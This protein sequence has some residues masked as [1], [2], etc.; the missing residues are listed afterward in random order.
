M[1]AKEIKAKLGE[2]Q[3]RSLEKLGSLQLKRL[4]RELQKISD[5]LDAIEYLIKTEEL[6]N[7][8]PLEFISFYQYF[9]KKSRIKRPKKGGTALAWEKY[10]TEMKKLT[11]QIQGKKNEYM[12]VFD[13]LIKIDEDTGI[14]LLSG[15]TKEDKKVLTILGSITVKT[16]RGVSTLALSEVE[17]NNR[18]WIQEVKNVKH[19]GVL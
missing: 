18:K 17:S 13:K 5:S 1:N 3:N 8:I 4:N 6:F 12:K 11:L 7:S 15:L 14:R 16:S 10:F 9:W 19:L 2:L